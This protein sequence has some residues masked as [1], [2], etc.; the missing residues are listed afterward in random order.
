M[1]LE[2]LPAAG[3][4]LADQGDGVLELALPPASASAG[5]ARRAL[6][7]YC[8]KHGVPAELRESGELVISELVT[9][10]VLHARTPFLVWP[11][12]T[13]AR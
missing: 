12:T 10:A 2:R 7:E 3:G 6:G 8:R 9:N 4:T 13:P 5:G 1:L 11:S